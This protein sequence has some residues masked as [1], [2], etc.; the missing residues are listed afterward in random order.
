[1]AAIE[2]VVTSGERVHDRET[3]N[4][5]LRECKAM[6]KKHLTL[7]DHVKDYIH[8]GMEK[9]E[10]YMTM[11]QNETSILVATYEIRDHMENWEHRL[12]GQ[13]LENVLDMLHCLF[14]LLGYDDTVPL[15]WSK[16]HSRLRKYIGVDTFK[17]RLMR[18]SETM[19]EGTTS[20]R[21]SLNSQLGSKIKSI[22]RLLHT[23]EGND[24][25]IVVFYDDEKH[26]A[27]K[28]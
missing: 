23:A 4:E 21:R 11:R 19:T 7:G 20:T 24:T 2:T 25:Y 9:I 1:M 6:E 16:S 18:F 22:T 28:F 5:F 12:S 27:C 8:V 3:L 13:V 14:L 10:Q 15:D 17:T 26:K